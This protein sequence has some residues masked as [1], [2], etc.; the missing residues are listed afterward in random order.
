VALIGLDDPSA[1]VLA[2][3]FHQFGI[4]TFSLA[5]GQAERMYTDRFDATAL[6]L[7]ESAERV[8]EIIRAVPANFR[9]VVYGLAK[10][11]AQALRFVRYGINAIIKEP[12][13]EQDVL[14]AIQATHLLVVH[15][16]RKYIRV[17]LITT[18]EVQAEGRKL[19]AMG[20]ELSSGGMSLQLGSKL[21]PGLLVELVFTLPN[22][23]PLRIP[24]SIRWARE[25]QIGVRFKES[26][27]NRR[28]LKQWLDQYLG[29]V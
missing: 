7:D 4:D 29:I 9:M 6:Y 10:T 24:A 20:E 21:L 3:C 2:G 26:D 17:P 19:M 23:A 14:R 28:R 15:E 16:F 27:P 8:L 22:A 12:V 13:E 5:G 18:V 25:G 1:A 11:T